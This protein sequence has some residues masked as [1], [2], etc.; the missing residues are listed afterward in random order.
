MRRKTRIAGLHFSDA[1][2]VVGEKVKIVGYLQWYDEETMRW[3]P[4]EH[5]KVKLLV[6]GVEVAETTT[7]TFGEFTFEVSFTGEHEVEVVFEGTPLLEGC[8][9]K[10]RVVAMSEDSR[11]RLMRLVRIFAILITLILLSI[12]LVAL[13]E[14]RGW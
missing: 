3:V 14:V 7:N 11:K 6:D 12:L 4:A 13:F 1:R 8:S 2:P 9:V 5:K 10:K